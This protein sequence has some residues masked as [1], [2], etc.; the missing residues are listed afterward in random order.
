MNSEELLKT[1]IKALNVSKFEGESVI[2]VMSRDQRVQDNHALLCA[3]KHALAKKLPLAVVF[4]LYEK[5]GVRAREHYEFMLDGLKQ[6]EKDLIELNIP[7][8]LLVGNPLERLSATFHHLRP[9]SVYFDF[10]PLKGPKMLQKAL[11][12]T[13]DCSMY[14]VDT[15]NVIPVWI[16]S[17]KRE[18][19]AYT[20]RPKIH[21][22]LADYLVEPEQVKAHPIK[23]PGKVKKISELSEVIES[24]LEN[25]KPSGI[26]I[27]F[28]SGEQA[29]KQHLDKFIDTKLATYAVDRNDPSKGGQSDLSPYL[30]FGQISSLRV[31]LLLQQEAH[32]NNSELHFLSSPK[33]P[34]PEDAQNTLQHGIDSLI[35]EM[36]VRKE[37]ADNFCYYDDNYDNLE[38]A[39]G[40]ARVSLDKHRDDPREFIYSLEQL[41]KAQTHDPAWNAS[42]RQLTQTGK[43]HGYMRMYWAKKVLDWSP[44]GAE[45][46]VKSQKSKVFDSEVQ[47]THSTFDLLLSTLH[48]PEWAIEVL[49]YLNDYYS[50]DGGDPNGYAG[51]MWSVAG[52]HDRPWMEREIFGVI[53]YMNYAGLKRK[54]NIEA[55]SENYI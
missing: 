55:Y 50:I 35:E 8:I 24:V 21:K 6:V 47:T 46:K 26:N 18:V 52:V 7:L 43:M 1:R 5:S 41:E 39:P 33:M 9:D 22:K 15:H 29:A 42:Q 13:L 40:W 34:K 45:S 38:S 16:T 48:G 23:W 51:I 31:A 14:V 12:E 25:I 32:K 4:C 27:E 11:S 44:P 17:E 49:K 54:Y 53:R 30:H 37:L 3:Q 10:N 28:K 36:I 19:G 20:I 2:Y